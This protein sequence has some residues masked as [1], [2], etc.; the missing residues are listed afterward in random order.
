MA[1]QT[2][3]RASVVLHKPRRRLLQAGAAAIGA[4]LSAVA[5]LPRP[6]LA[7]LKRPQAS[8]LAVGFVYV[9]PIGDGGWTFQHDLGRLELEKAAAGAVRTTFVANVA[10]GPDAE[11][12]IRDLAL[13]QHQLIFST[14]FGYMDPTLRVAKE[15]PDVAF[16][17]AGGYKLADNLATYN[18]RVYEGRYLAGVLAAHATRSKV[19][20]FVAAMP[21]P[22]VLQGINA[23]TIG[24]REVDP[25]IETRVIWTNSWFDPTREQEAAAT[26]VS[27]K[28][29]V[30]THH[31]DSSA[32][33][34]AAESLGVQV[35]GYHS[36]MSAF[37]PKMHLAS[38]T[39][40]W[41]R[42]YSARAKA[43][44]A[45]EWRSETTWGGMADDMVR[46]EAVSPKVSPT[47]RRQVARLTAE[48]KAFH[49]HPFTGPL[50]SNDG[51]P[52]LPPNERIGD[53]E[54]SRMDWLV[55]GVVGKV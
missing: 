43:L 34:K 36:N 5:S 11:R 53:T 4:G 50:M 39:H 22:E 31:T 44:L 35:I 48:I 6:L 37:A 20:G 52:A 2:T 7:Q 18:A 42:Y 23:F 16:E 25:T 51:K 14:S 1:L 28:A 41:G 40:H 29:D 21:I 12:V 19:L 33:V 38:V 15:F 47:A 49:R 17:H 8:P 55:E 32:V 26:L 3:G 27:Q 9:S 45:G 10:E 46:L 54:L 30:I 24:A 13:Q